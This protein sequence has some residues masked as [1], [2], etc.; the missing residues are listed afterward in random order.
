VIF[1]DTLNRAA[2]TIDENS[3]KDMGEVLEAARQ[4]QALTGGM[5]ILVHHSGKDASKGPRGHSSQVPTY[6]SVI[7]VS[8]D[9][10]RRQWRASKSKDG[11]AGA[12]HPFKLAIEPLG[13][14]KHGDLNTSC[15]VVPDA[16]DSQIKHVRVPQGANQ[17]MVLDILRP[18]FNQGERAKAGAPPQ[19]LCIELEAAISSVSKQLTCETFRRTTRARE[20]ISGLVAKGVF[21]CSEGWIWVV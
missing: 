1:I 11:P 7:E 9:G 6:D 13:V 5:V 20:A 21:G 4:L 10:D 12:L 18:M 16:T 14:D 8:R 17:R 2:P 3:S 19:A 15:V